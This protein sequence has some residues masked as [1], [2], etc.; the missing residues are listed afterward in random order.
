MVACGYLFGFVIFGFGFAWKFG[1]SPEVL[2]ITSGWDFA[3]CLL[4]SFSN[5]DSQDHSIQNLPIANTL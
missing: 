1:F 4:S 2:K 5:G 3:L